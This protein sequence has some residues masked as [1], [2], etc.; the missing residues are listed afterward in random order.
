MKVAIFAAL[1]LQQK[2]MSFLRAYCTDAAVNLGVNRCN[3]AEG[4]PAYCSLRTFASEPHGS[5]LTQ[6]MSWPSVI[7]QYRKPVIFLLSGPDHL[8][9]CTKMPAASSTTS[10]AAF[11]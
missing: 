7:G 6:R 1:I 9:E 8:L 11:S 2:I 3:T 5:M 4:K 10:A